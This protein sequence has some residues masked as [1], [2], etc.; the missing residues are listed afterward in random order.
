[1]WRRRWR[2]RTA[3]L[4]AG[5]VCPSR[6][7]SRFCC[8]SRARCRERK[9]E[10]C[11]WLVFEVGKN[12][13]EADADVAETHRLSGVLRAR[14]AA[15]GRGDDAH[16][17]SGRA[18]PAALYSAG[19][20]RGDSAV[21]LS[22]RHYGGHD[23]G[24]DRVTGNTVVL[25]PSVDSPTIA[26]QFF[27]LLEEAGMPDG[28]VNFCPGEGLALARAVVA[29]PQTRFI[30]FTGSKKVGWRSTS[31][32]RRRSRDSTFIKRTI[33]EMGGKDAIIVD[34]D[35]DLD[36]AVEGVAAAAFGFNGQKCSACSRAIV[37]ESVY[38]IFCDALVERVGAI[39]QGDPAENFSMRAGD[40]RGR[41]EEHSGLHRDR[42]EGRPAADRRRSARDIR[43]AATTLSRRCLPISR[44]RRALAQEEI[45]GPV[46]AVIKS[47]NFDDALAI[48]NDTE[49]GLTG[50][51]YTTRARSWTARARSS[52]W[53]TC[54]STANAREQWWAR[55]RLAAST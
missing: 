23:G 37:D 46:L 40:Q 8:E 5:A 4:P 53:A 55:I 34:A 3:P 49:F 36:A 39:K 20:G 28:V 7:G 27:E 43:T 48:A 10:F 50:A 51:V 30:A 1:M 6:S 17:V 47:H 2:R 12:W 33:L 25:K 26:A 22:L 24:G 31:A 41:V 11:A 45:F 19:R 29:H 21:E 52:M 18:E 32:R 14:G 16:P 15:A 38:D 35:C 54:T 42:Q 9:L 44:P 13:A